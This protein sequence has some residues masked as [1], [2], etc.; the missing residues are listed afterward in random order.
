MTDGADLRDGLFWTFAEELSACLCSELDAA[1]GGD[2]CFCGVVYGEG[3]DRSLVPVG[4]CGGAAWVRLDQS[5]PS[6]NFPEPDQTANCNTLLAAVIEVG[7]MR[8]VAVG[9]DRRAPSLDERTLDARRQFSDM[10]AMHRAISCCVG[11]SK[12]DFVYL[13][14]DYQPFGPEGGI[15]GG[16]WTMTLQQEF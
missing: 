9:S 4:R 14:G 5:Y 6:L 1:G 7:V 11:T 15:S 10:S 12:L 3:M 16:T 8:T 2:L 13:L